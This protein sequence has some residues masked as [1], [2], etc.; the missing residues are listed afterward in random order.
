[1][2]LD[3]SKQV[4]GC[5]KDWKGKREWENCMA[6]VK[7]SAKGECQRVGKMKPVHGGCGYWKKWEGEAPEK[8]A[9]ESGE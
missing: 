9:E 2:D 4:C 1:M 7:A 5:C 8:E 3:G 6:K